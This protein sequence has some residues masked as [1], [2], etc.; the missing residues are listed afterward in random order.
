MGDIAASVNASM[1]WM[2]GD[3]F[4]NNG[5]KD[6]HDPRFQETFE[7]VFVAPSLM[8][9]PFWIVGGNHDHY[10][11]ITGEVEYSNHSKRWTFPS[12]YYTQSWP[13]PGTNYVLQVV[14]IDTVDLCGYS[15]GLDSCK[16]R[17]IPAEDCLVQPEGPADAELAELQWRWINE[18]LEAST[19]DFLVVAGHFPVWSIAEHGPTLCLVELL[20]P[21]MN[22]NNVNFYM[23]GHD[24]TFELI[25]EDEYPDLLYVTTGGAHYCDSS[26]VH[27][28]FI[29]KH[30]LKFHGCDKGGFIRVNIGAAG[31]YI[32]YYFGTGDKV[33]YTS[34]TYKPRKHN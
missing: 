14:M 20:R 30:S 34:D 21:T 5:V 18:T 23:N 10:G 17:G 31:M 12:R 7:N 6:E 15:E 11:N 4:Y 28:P 3:N 27:E 24:H 29:P 33:Q 32:E 9:I 8:D 16:E 22:A 26:I 1:A 13:V 19:A 25:I 2:L